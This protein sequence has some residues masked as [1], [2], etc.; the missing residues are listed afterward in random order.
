MANGSHTDIL[1]VGAGAAGLMA[2]IAAGRAM[3][4][5]GRVVLLDG[6][7]RIGAKILVSGG[8]RC[9]VTHD[10][11]T[12]EDYAGSKRNQIAKVL[13]T[14]SVEKTIAFFREIGVELKREDTGKLFPVS[15]SARMV[16]D[17]LL[18]AVDEAGCEL[19]AGHRVE[20]VQ[21]EGDGF[22]V[23]TERG[24]FQAKRVILATGGKSLPKTGSDGQGYAFAKALGHSVTKT[25]PALVPLVLEKGHWLTKLS[26]LAADVELMVVSGTGKVLQRQAGAMLLTHFGLSGPGVMDISRH[27][28]AAKATDPGAKL[29]ANLLPGRS[30]E[31]VDAELVEATQKRGKA[32]VGSVVSELLPKRLAEALVKEAC[33]IEPGPGG[34][35]VQVSQLGKVQR[36]ELAHA[37]TGLV[38]PVVRDRGYL[39]AE[40]TAG[41]VPLDEVDLATMQSRKCAGLYLCGEVLDVDGRI[42]G[43]NFQWAWS[44]G[45]LAGMSA[46]FQ[47]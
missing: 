40:V 19:L 26:G 3:R 7:E 2:G 5:N 37:L 24:A 47:N 32:G 29:Q 30:F 36:R 8:G 16:L 9:N 22:S 38:L 44:S 25:T 27:W 17:A 28:I 46:G 42:G 15:D 12:A 31:E 18:K 13:R 23:S 41:G 39:F 11:V 1:I 20:T 6:A 34:P 4:G 45:R 43:Y 14:F 35:G 10:V 21:P 33:G